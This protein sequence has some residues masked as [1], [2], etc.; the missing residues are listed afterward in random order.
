MRSTCSK[1][2]AFLAIAATAAGCALPASGPRGRTINEEATTTLALSPA[3][4]MRKFVLLDV[5]ARVASGLGDAEVNSFF[6]TFGP[7]ARRLTRPSVLFNRGDVLQ[8][9]IFESRKGGLFIDEDS[10]TRPGNFVQLPPQTVDR[11]G[12]IKVPYAG[13]IY[14]V[15]RTAEDVQNEVE[16]KLSQRA[17]EPQVFITTNTQRGA[18]IAVLGDVNTA[19]KFPANPGGE[20]VIDVISRAGGIKSPGYETFVTLQRNGRSAKVLFDRLVRTPAENVF[21]QPGDAVYV[22]REPRSYTVLGATETNNRVV[23]P[24]ERVTLVEAI[25]TGGGLA[26]L[27]A[28]PAYV[29]LYR[30]EPRDTLSRVGVDL[31]NFDPG[32]ALIPVIYKANLQESTAL[33]AAQQ[34][35]VRDKDVLYVANAETV[36]LVKL[37]GVFAAVASPVASGATANFAIA[38]SGRL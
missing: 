34:F 2:A 31:S 1:A 32:E 38:R 17:I 15:G 30:A 21:V 5:S 7:S 33:F 12:N 25:G 35:E 22:S 14:V 8:M 29:Y 3:D 23:F 18:E 6:R 4:E 24:A 37:F 10:G 9:T 19:N 20:R 26:D 36:E 11:D 13:S 16:Q 28:N 27:R